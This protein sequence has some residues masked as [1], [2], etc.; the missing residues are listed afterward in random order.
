M[1]RSA[2][3][4]IVPRRGEQ[5]FAMVT[6]LIVMVVVS[7]LVVVMLTTQDHTTTA[8]ARNRSWGAA[9]HVAESGVH[10]AI[11]YLQSTNGVPPTGVQQGTT[12]EGTWQYRV[13]ALPRNHYQIDAVGSVGQTAALAAS[14]RLR[15]LLAPP[16]S[17]RYALFSLSDV[18]TK[19]N[20]VVCGDVWA[21]TYVT[22]YQGD[23]VLAAGAAG[24]PAGAI[25]SGHVTAATGW[26]ELQGSSSVDGNI[27]SGGYDSAGTAVTVGNKGRVGGTI[28]A[29]SSTPACADDPSHA[30][31]K[32]VNDGTASSSI[33]TWGSISGGGTSGTRNAL[34]CSTAAAAAQMPT[35]AWNPAN[36][37]AATL[38]TY[39]FPA[40]YSA[41]NAYVAANQG[42][43]QGTFYIAGGDATTPIDLT[44]VNIAGDTTIV[45]TGSPINANGVGSANATDKVLVLVSYYSA[46]ASGCTTVGGN[47]ADCA[48]GFK[49]NFDMSGTSLSAG[50]NTAAL[51][52]APNGP[53]AFKNNAQFNGAV[54]ANNIQVKNNMSLAYDPRVD[55]IVGFGTV[56]LDINSWMECT[57]GAV[58]TSSC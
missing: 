5:G 36:Y 29:S 42:G 35:F 8:T 31:Y 2:D 21:N 53:I 15:V 54:Y 58:T 27:W 56:T 16:T 57:P 45:A 49:N 6:M 44:G 3:P 48:I 22:V 47:P 10:E 41:F 23:S 25:G 7:M 4:P 11:A 24:C 28:K 32:V 18:T 52:F 1:N 43:L 34:T 26:V 51:L 39:T 19:N 14:R 40:D 55:Q 13:T 17:F 38:H 46:P 50:S 30:R 12:A 9:V 37:P 33:T 20:N